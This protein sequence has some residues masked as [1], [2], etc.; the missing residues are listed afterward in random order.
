MNT[1]N[2]KDFGL[3]ERFIN[4]STMYE[5]MTVGRVV[6]Q[7][8]DLYK[9]ITENG[10]KK[11]HISGKFRYNAKNIL[12]F[13]AVGDFVM[14]DE[15]YEAGGSSVIHHVLTRKSSFVRKAAGTSGDLQVVAANIDTVFICMSLNNDFNIRRLERYIGICW[16]SGATPV[17]VLTKS[18]LC[19]DLDDKMLAVESAALGIDIAVTSSLSENGFASVG[20]YMQN[21][22]TIAFIGSSGVGKTSLINRLIGEDTFE[23]NGLRNDDKGRHT[24]TRRELI[25]LP[26]KGIVIDTPGMRELGID[27]ADLGKTFADIEELSSRCR[28]NDCTHTREPGCAVN[29]AIDTGL[30]S[31]D[32]LESYFKLKKESKYDGLNSKQ[33]EKEKINSMF[34]SIGGIKNLRKIVKNKKNGDYN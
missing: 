3:N 29:E 4:E 32:R 12:D 19:E 18:D 9:I 28:F 7:Y 33:I 26:G 8:K 5:G 10:E 25:L 21:G 30:L 17:I 31:R 16:D 34:K 14:V 27:S 24:T 20:E 13:P 23:V 6:S 1:I 2:M 15:N 11:A 22:R